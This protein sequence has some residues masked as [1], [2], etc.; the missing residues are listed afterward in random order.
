MIE[1]ADRPQTCIKY[2]HTVFRTSFLLPCFSPSFFL[3]SLL[4]PCLFNYLLFMPTKFF[5]P[6]LIK[7]YT[8]KEI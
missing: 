4:P 7:T 5:C 6:Y 2:E 3:L 8:V 1:L